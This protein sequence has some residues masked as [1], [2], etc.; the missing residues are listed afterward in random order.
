MYGEKVVIFV[1]IFLFK[2]VPIY[3]DSSVVM[4]EKVHTNTIYNDRT[5]RSLNDINNQ[6]IYFIRIIILSF[7]FSICIYKSQTIHCPFLP[8]YFTI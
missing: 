6:L 2:L 3:Y 8:E 1:R 4:T 5:P 7:S